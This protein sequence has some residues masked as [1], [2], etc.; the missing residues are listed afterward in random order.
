MLC[1]TVM[2]SPFNIG[3]RYIHFG[4]Y[5][6]YDFAGT[7]KRDY[8]DHIVSTSKYGNRNDKTTTT[9]DIKIRDYENWRKYDAGICLGVGYWFGKFNLDFTWQRGFIGVFKSGDEQV[10]IGKQTRDQGTSS[11]TTSS[12]N[13]VTHFNRPPLQPHHQLDPQYAPLHRPQTQWCFFTQ[14]TILIR[15]LQ[16]ADGVPN[17]RNPLRHSYQQW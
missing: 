1:H 14:S 10:K 11:P 2:L 6:S 4:V 9:T 13:S 17:F 15:K 16:E 5:A 7:Y 12:S 3:Y 8:T